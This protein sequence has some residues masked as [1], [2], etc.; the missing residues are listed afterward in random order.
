MPL[1]RFTRR[2]PRTALPPFPSAGTFP[3]LPAFDDLDSRMNKLIERV[4]TDP[5]AVAL[6]EAIGWVPAMDIVEK[7]KEFLLTAELPGLDEKNVDVSV[8][9]GLL[10]IK[11]EKTEEKEEKKE[12]EEEKKF[13]LYERSYG[14]FSRSFALPPNV[15]ATKID[16]EFKKGLLKVHLPKM[17]EPKS[18][19][20]KVDIKTA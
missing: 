17:A 6:P 16:A 10:T 4:F 5:F 19:G 1:V 14:S 11:G 12:R 2:Q 3:A 15:D 7:E 18:N 13:Y 20:R 9:E 8:E